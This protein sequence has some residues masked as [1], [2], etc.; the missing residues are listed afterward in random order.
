MIGKYTDNDFFRKLTTKEQHKYLKSII[1][2]MTNE[3]IKELI[4]KINNVRAEIMIRQLIEPNV[5]THLPIDHF[6]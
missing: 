1:S 2:G 4:F 5:N 3:E 6:F